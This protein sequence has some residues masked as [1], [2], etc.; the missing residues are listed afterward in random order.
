MLRAMNKRP[1]Y[2]R[3]PVPPDAFDSARTQERKVPVDGT[4]EISLEDV[5]EVRNALPS[6]EEIDLVDVVEEPRIVVPKPAHRVAKQPLV[7]VNAT[8]EIA[9]EDVLEARFA[10]V[11]DDDVDA[12]VAQGHM[13]HEERS[14]EAPFAIDT[15]ELRKMDRDRLT[16]LSTSEITRRKQ[17]GALFVGAAVGVALAVLGVAG[18]SQAMPMQG[19][20]RLSAA[21]SL[22]AGKSKLSKS[23]V[24]RSLI[25]AAEDTVALSI[26]VDA[27]PKAVQAPKA[28]PKPA[29]KAPPKAQPKTRRR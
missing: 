7:S 14:S 1:L 23:H 21:S 3:T 17:R 15:S 5:L 29:T 2:V 18:L 22:V 20:D 9:L 10:P 6:I 13:F 28:W 16:V 12:F 27:L 19:G 24:Q 11:V 25:E 8:Q 26:P 4:G